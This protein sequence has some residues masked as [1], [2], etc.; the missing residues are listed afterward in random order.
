MKPFYHTL[1]ICLFSL[2]LFNSCEEVIETNIDDVT[3]EMVM[4]SNFTSD[5]ELEVVVTSTKPFASN[6]NII[7]VIVGADVRVYE[8]EQFIEKLE[9]F[10]PGED[11]GLPPYYRSI[12]FIP[13][14]GVLY[15]IKVT[16]SG[17]ATLENVKK[18]REKLWAGI[19]KMAFK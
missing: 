11:S 6:S 18:M 12:N 2:F 13:Q 3:N 8:G 4:S 7:P 14:V 19:P 16:A 1:I 9:L 17:L 10:D 15:T 5:H